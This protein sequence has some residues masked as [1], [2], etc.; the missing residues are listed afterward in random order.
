MVPASLAHSINLQSSSRMRP[1]SHPTSSTVTRYNNIRANIPC[2]SDPLRNRNGCLLLRP[3]LDTPFSPSLL[4]S[5]KTNDNSNTQFPSL[6]MRSRAHK[7][8][9]W[10]VRQLLS[11]LRQ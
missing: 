6:L 8:L 1:S 7:G 4:L 11:F 5:Y 9:L 3:R 10:L 2:S